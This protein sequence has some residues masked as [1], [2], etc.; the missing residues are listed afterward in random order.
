MNK[1]ILL[2]GASGLVGGN[3][4]KILENKGTHITLL[5]RKKI[6]NKFHHK[7]I[8]SDFDQIN[9]IDEQSQIDEIYIAI[10]KK[11]SLIELIYMRK[12][13]RDSFEKV[14]YEYIKN[15]A[16]LGK[17]LGAKSIGL[18]SAVGANH[19]SKNIYLNV[20]GKIEKEIQSIGFKKVVIARPGHL[21]GQ[22]NNEKK[23][24]IIS[25]FEL[26]TNIF[27]FFMFGPLEK[28]KNIS[29]SKVAMSLVSEMENASEG[30]HYLEYS[31][32]KNH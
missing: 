3:I 25:A 22:R 17:R 18:I 8:V 19:N 29:A 15:I 28:Y 31:N 11:L 30:S 16:H 27:N 21:L 24:W 5:L 13:D 23:S 4:L 14:D 6:T 1:K 32:F 20:K 9:S 10:G 26:I 2:A 7:Q 12:K